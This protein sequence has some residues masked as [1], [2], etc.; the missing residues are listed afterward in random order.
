MAGGDTE[1]DT[2]DPIPNSVVK[3]LRADGSD[4]A[5][6]RE[7]RSLP[8]FFLFLLAH[9]LHAQRGANTGGGMNQ[10]QCPHCYATTVTILSSDAMREVMTIQCLAC[11]RQAEIDTEQ[12]LVDTEDLPQE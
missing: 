6:D 8:A 3:P 5:R 10:V 2:P 1:G 11:G 9:E 4:P 12:F 7:S